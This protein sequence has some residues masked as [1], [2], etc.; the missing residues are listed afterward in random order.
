V[1]EKR[2]YYNLWG[3]AVRTATIMAEA[4]V[5]GGIHVSESTYQR[6]RSGYVFKKRGAFYLEETGEIQ[7]YLL[8]GRL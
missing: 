8:T 3:D 4:G 1:G 2:D 7:T 5:L 6:L